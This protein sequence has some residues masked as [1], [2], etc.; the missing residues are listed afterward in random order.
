[1]QSVRGHSR[2]GIVK[3][4]FLP[5]AA[6]RWPAKPVWGAARLL[7]T[8]YGCTKSAHRQYSTL[9]ARDLERGGKYIYQLSMRGDECQESGGM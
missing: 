2:R 3:K 8:V 9:V 4:I 7:G 6:L 1:M 5:V